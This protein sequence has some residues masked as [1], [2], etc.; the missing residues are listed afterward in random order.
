MA[1]L[2]SGSRRHPANQY[3]LINVE[4]PSKSLLV[5]K[6]TAKLPMKK[7]D[8]TFEAP[9][10]FDPVSH[11]GGLKMHVNDQSYKSFLLWLQDY[12]DTVN[13]RYATAEDLPEDNWISTQRILRIKDVP[14]SWGK[15]TVVQLFVYATN[16]KGEWNEKP[17][18][19]TQGTITP[20]RLVNGALF[21][22]RREGGQPAR[23]VTQVDAPG[24]NARGQNARGPL[25]PGKY[26]IKA[27]VDSKDRIAAQPTILLGSDEFVGQV[28]IDAQWQ[29]GFPKAQTVSA[30]EF[31]KR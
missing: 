25:R 24:Q 22:F 1:R 16:D 29:L 3:P 11:M 21:V 8:G 5:L 4:E 14:E 26:L 7:D 2:I 10:S 28:V 23:N 20:R 18:A 31:A 27:Y 9:S 30:S 13:G 6:P 17:L 19:F 12:S 15:L